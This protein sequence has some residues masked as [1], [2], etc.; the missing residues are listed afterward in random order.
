MAN[1][2]IHFR[3]SSQFKNKLGNKH[4]HEGAQQ[5]RALQSAPKEFHAADADPIELISGQQQQRKKKEIYYIYSV[6]CHES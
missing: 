5:K 3:I 6:L 2:K 1:S 4:T